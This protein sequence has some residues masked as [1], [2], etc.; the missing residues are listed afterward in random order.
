MRASYRR[1]LANDGGLG[2]GLRPMAEHPKIRTRFAP[3]PTGYLHVGGARTALFNWLLAR[4]HGGTFVLRIEDTDEAR[5]T[6][7]ARQAILDGLR[8]LGIDWDEGPE[9]GG[10][11][12][13]YF[14]SERK[15]IY[16]HYFKRLEEAGVV[17]E[18][19]GAWRFRFP[20][21]EVVVEDQI[22]GTISFDPTAEPDMTVRRPDGS[23]IFHFVNVVD[24]IEMGITHL[25]RGE[26]HLANTWKHILLYQALGSVPPVFAHIPLILNEDGSKMSKRD[27]GASLKGYSDS[28][29]LPKAVK[30]YLCLLGWSPKD[31]SEKLSNDAMVSRFGLEGINGSHAS[32]DLEKCRWLNGQYLAELSPEDFAQGALA[33]IDSSLPLFS[34]DYALK[35]LP[36]YQ[37]KVRTFCELPAMTDYMF[38]DHYEPDAEAVAKMTEREGI[39]GLLEGLRSHLAVVKAWQAEAINEAIAAAA[40]KQKLKQGA[41]MFPA[42]VA[43]SGRGGGPE[44][45]PMLELL[46]QERVL[47]RIGT[48]SELL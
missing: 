16:D 42:R 4:H 30:N 15:D 36:L 38:S 28:G 10:A 26:D 31:D 40:E 23:Y 14:Q 5:N 24:D 17:Y 41:L 8:W 11:H 43:A 13:P 9:V 2:K 7:E 37:S 29:F 47:A 20:A 18:D 21:G 39:A 6:V 33:F 44:L 32:F 27:T 46:G 45:L 34:Q 3:S 25:L 19:G 48:A 12:G 35:V 22:C 1:W